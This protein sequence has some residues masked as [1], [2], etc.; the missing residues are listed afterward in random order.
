MS[1][2]KLDQLMDK[3]RNT[4]MTVE[5]RIVSPKEWDILQAMANENMLSPS[6]YPKAEFVEEYFR[7]INGE[8]N[9]E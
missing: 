6:R 3:I 2:E 5:P 8:V 7:R 9:D 1:K 4:G